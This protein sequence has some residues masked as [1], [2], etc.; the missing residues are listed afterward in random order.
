MQ[1]NNSSFQTLPTG[2]PH[3]S[4]SEVKLWKECSFRHK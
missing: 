4:F 2:K 1:E 3:V